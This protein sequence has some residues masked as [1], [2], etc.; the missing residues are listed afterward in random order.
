MLRFVSLSALSRVL[1]LLPL[2]LACSTRPP[3]LGSYETLRRHNIA[4]PHV[5]IEGRVALRKANDGFSSGFSLQQ[6]PDFSQMTLTGPLGGV[7]ARLTLTPE[8]CRLELPDREPIAGADADALLRDFFGYAIPFSALPFWLR[9]V[10]QSEHEKPRLDEQHLPQAFDENG[11]HI[12]YFAWQ[13]INGHALPQKMQ[14]RNDELTL[15]IS[16]H[17]WHF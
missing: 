6:Q 4:L 13:Y 16:L 15:K 12:D 9:G 5:Y 1:C 3:T 11:W 10:M 7:H 14:I 8:S 2:L 17:D